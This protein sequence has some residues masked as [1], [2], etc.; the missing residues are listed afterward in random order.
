MG[1]GVQGVDGPVV[2]G[3]DDVMGWGLMRHVKAQSPGAASTACGAGRRTPD[4]GSGKALSLRR[5]ART[6]QQK[7][8][9][10]RPSKRARL[11][12]ASLS[13]TSPPNRQKVVSGA[14]L[15]FIT[16]GMGGGTGTGA[17]PVV[18]KLSKDMGGR[19]D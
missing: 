16:A 4:A 10:F 15:V 5:P 11:S 13:P 17:A 6:G 9:R 1:G 7:L 19:P 14:D 3:C 2:N 8:Q 18:A 12:S